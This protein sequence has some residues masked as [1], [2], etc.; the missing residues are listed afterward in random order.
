MCFVDNVSLELRMYS[1]SEVSKGTPD[2]DNTQSQRQ[3]M[4]TYFFIGYSST[5]DIHII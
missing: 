1:C 2:P 3:Y 5:A 4:S